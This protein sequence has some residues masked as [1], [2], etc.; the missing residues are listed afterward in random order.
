MEGQAKFGPPVIKVSSSDIT[1]QFQIKKD[2][3]NAKVPSLVVIY[4]PGCIHCKMMEPEYVSGAR[5]YLGKAQFLA[6]DGKLPKNTRLMKKMGV[7]SFPTIL[8]VK[9]G[10]LTPVKFNKERKAKHFYDFA[11]S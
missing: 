11:N 7:T 9:N 10:F 8:K 6:I 3:V 5:K 4:S 2:G 1:E